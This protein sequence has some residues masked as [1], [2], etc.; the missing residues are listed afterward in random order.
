MLN[1]SLWWSLLVELVGNGSNGDGWY[2][3]EQSGWLAIQVANIVA[4]CC[5]FQYTNLSQFRTL[6]LSV[7][8]CWKK[9]WEV[10]DSMYAKVLHSPTIKFYL[11]FYSKELLNLYLT[12]AINRENQLKLHLKYI[13]Q[14]YLWYLRRFCE[15]IIEYFEAPN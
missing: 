1:S 14:A 12:T 3:R 10:L 6:S 5:Y 8:M 13:F 9:W 7:N 15:D 4:R 2:G 11:N